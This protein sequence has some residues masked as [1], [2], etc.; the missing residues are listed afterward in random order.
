MIDPV[1]G[2]PYILTKESKPSTTAY[3]YSYPLPLDPRNIKT[4]KLE[5]TF[6]H[7]KPRFSAGDV[8]SDGRWI[9]ARNANYFYTYWRGDPTKSFAAAFSNLTCRFD[10]SNGL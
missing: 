9:L 5:R 7:P 6:P 10:G 8:S 1:D 4:L 3:L 2:R